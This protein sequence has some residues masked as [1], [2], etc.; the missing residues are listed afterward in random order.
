[1]IGY[2]DVAGKV[3]AGPGAGVYGPYVQQIPTNPWNDK[4][5]VRV[6]VVATPPVGADTDGWQF[7]STTGVFHADDI[8]STADD[9]AHSAL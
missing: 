6:G 9:T 3:A 7:D 4:D 1:M 2:T 8:L 5:S